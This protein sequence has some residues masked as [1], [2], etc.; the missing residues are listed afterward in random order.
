[1]ASCF[2]F[3]LPL[4]FCSLLAVLTFPTVSRAVNPVQWTIVE[5]IRRTDT[6]KTWTSPTAIDLGKM[7]WEYDYE[8]TKVTG[9]VNVPFLGEQTQDITGSIPADIR[10]GAGET[11][12]LPAVLLDETIEEPE[13]GTSAHVMVE[14]DN[15]GFGRAVFSDI[16]LGSVNVPLFGSRP[17]ERINV[18]ATVNVI[19]IDY[20][21][22]TRDGRIDAAD[23]VAWR[24]TDGTA[25][26]YAWWR[27][28]FGETSNLSGGAIGV[29]AS[30]PEPASISLMLAVLAVCYAAG[31]KRLRR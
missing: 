29:A 17:I 31:R 16:M 23:Y 24:E 10:I 12:N 21:D 13:S 20:G 28:N 18:E 26:G 1:M 25:T 15:S 3:R 19:G 27:T 2:A 9:T 8:I 11:T 22:F 30:V 4:A 5:E 6:M 7:V 14:V